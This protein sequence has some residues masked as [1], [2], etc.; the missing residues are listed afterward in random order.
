MDEVSDRRR[1]WCR[2][3]EKLS[4]RQLLNTTKRRCRKNIKECYIIGVTEELGLWIYELLVWQG[5]KVKVKLSLCLTKH[6]SMKTYWG[7][8]DISSRI[9]DL[10]T[11]WRWVF[12]F[13]PRPLYLQGKSPWYP[14][15]RRL[16][17]IQSPVWRRWSRE[18]FPAPAGNRTLELRSSNP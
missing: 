14:L 11:R 7:S 1:K 9:L 10:G 17:G 12:S 5:W 15:D 4:R 16:G 18:K 6:H 8:G 3:V 13:T 2:S